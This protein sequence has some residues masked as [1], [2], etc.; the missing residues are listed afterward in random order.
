MGVV[1][2]IS[3]RTKISRKLNDAEKIPRRR[4]EPWEDPVECAGPEVVLH[5]LSKH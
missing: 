2:E 5:D 1:Q 4:S 3:T